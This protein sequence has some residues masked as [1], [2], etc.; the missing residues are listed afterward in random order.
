VGGRATDA[1]R[2][3]PNLS[4]LGVG[5]AADVERPATEAQALRSKGD[6]SRE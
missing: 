1:W 4:S 2:V 3:M 5:V 6:A